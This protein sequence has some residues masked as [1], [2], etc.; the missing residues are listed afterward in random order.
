MPSVP[1]A[2][3]ISMQQIVQYWRRCIDELEAGLADTLVASHIVGVVANP[4]D[5]SWAEAHPAYELIFEVAASLEMPGGTSVRRSR[6]WACIRAL[7]AVL[8]QEYNGKE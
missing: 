6:A 4:N 5:D 1:P 3:L 7:L 8:E 2:R